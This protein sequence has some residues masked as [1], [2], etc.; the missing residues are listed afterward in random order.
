MLA[1][2]ALIAALGSP[3]ADPRIELYTMGQGEHVFERFGH[4]AICVVHDRQPARSRCYNY[5]TTDFGSP[6]EELGWAFLRGRARFWVSVWPL[7]RMLRSYQKSDRTIWRQRLPL[8]PEQVARVE[9]KLEHD[10]HEDNRYYLYHHFFDN[11]STRVRDIVD[12]VTGGRLGSELPYPKTFR[13]LG[14][15]GLAETAPA[16]V[17][18]DLLVGRDADRQPTLREAMFLPDVMRREVHARLGARPELVYRRQGRAF[19]QDPPSNAPWQLAMAAFV[20]LPAGATRLARRGGRAGLVV[21]GVLLGVLGLVVW[22]VAAVSSVPEL[23]TNEV[24]LVFWPSD[25]LL[26]ALNETWRRRYARLRLSVLLAIS[27]LA[28]TSVLAQPL[29]LWVLLAALPM[30]LALGGRQEARA[31]STTA[32]TA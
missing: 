17:L 29:L 5:G 8:T 2:A 21:S 24:L 13:Q 19:V 7:E 28:V 12:E 11:C 25:V 32:A 31:S 18:G 22:L 4:A 10:A 15:E 26:G 30:A 23:C 6:P 9:A 27:A 1:P 3:P 16:L 14:R 20:A